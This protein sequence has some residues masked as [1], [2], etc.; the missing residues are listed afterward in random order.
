LDKIDLI[1]NNKTICA[2]GVTQTDITL[3][4]VDKR[5]R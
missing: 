3:L 1:D 4:R 2:L 5:S